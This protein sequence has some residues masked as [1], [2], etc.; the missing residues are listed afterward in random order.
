M[1]RDGSEN[2]R[3]ARL[4]QAVG[5]WRAWVYPLPV[6]LAVA[7]A[8]VFER[9]LATGQWFDFAL[10]TYAGELGTPVDE[11]FLAPLS[12]LAYPWLIVA[13]AILLASMI[14]TPIL[15]AVMHRLAW[16]VGLAVTVGVLG[17][18]PLLSLSLIFACVLAA[19]TPLRHDA[20]FLAVLLGLLVAAGYLYLSVLAGS[21]AETVL[22]IQ[23]WALRAPLVL[24]VVLAVIVAAMVLRLGRWLRW[25]Y[26]AVWPLLL[27]LPIPAGAIFYG[28][29]GTVELEYRRIVAQIHADEEIFAPLPLEEWRTRAGAEGLSGSALRERARDDLDRRRRELV[30]Q[31]E[32]FLHRHPRSRRSAEITWLSAQCASLR[33][34]EPAY[35]AGTVRCTAALAPPESRP[36]WEALLRDYPGGPHAGLAGRRAGELALRAGDCETGEQLLLSAVDTLRALLQHSRTAPPQVFDDHDAIPSRPYY[37]QALFQAERLL[38]LVRENDVHDSPPAAAA[39]AELLQ[40]HPLAFDRPAYLRRLD[41]LAAR[42]ENT[43][44]AGNLKVAYALADPDPHRRATQLAL[45][46]RQRSDLDAAVQAN[47]ELGLLALQR[48]TVEG[49]EEVR[50]PGEHFGLVHAAPPNPFSALAA[51][52]LLQLPPPS[53]DPSP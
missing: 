45:L 5:G 49:V 29:V 26:A 43:P 39:L 33:L 15:V 28:H 10:S 31:C 17:H 37:E 13:H 50:S 22:P 53:R 23:R 20:P 48:Q 19:R 4:Q 44:L 16:G 36:R 46:A 38:W 2:M 32:Q 41:D 27:V 1:A 51:R 42:H 34:H 9:Y 6:W 30:D 35:A 18:W 8:A 14:G 47:F 7:A 11:G 12:V 24:A 25:H 21:L 3:P 52:R 40:T